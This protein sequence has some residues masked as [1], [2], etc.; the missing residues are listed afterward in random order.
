MSFRVPSKVGF[1]TELI[2]EMILL[3][4]TPLKLKLADVTGPPPAS[5]SKVP[6]AMGA[7]AKGSSVIRNVAALAGIAIIP[8]TASAAKSVRTD[9]I[10][11]FLSMSGAAASV[12]SVESP[13]MA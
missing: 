1:A 10:R 9:L 6:M 4:V 13:A 2:G 8:T 12:L 3:Y 11:I 5:A 7:E